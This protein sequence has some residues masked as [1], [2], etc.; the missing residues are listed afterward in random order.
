[1][2]SFIGTLNVF[3]ATAIDPA[4]GSVAVDGQILR[5]G[6][7][8]DAKPGEALGLS[9]RPEA[10]PLGE[11]PNALEGRV[12]NI[13]L[14]GSIVRLVVSPE[15]ILFSRPESAPEHLS[16]IEEE[17]IAGSVTKL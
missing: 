3:P 15:A 9:I 13:K 2:A 14:L 11:G 4:A 7:R 6:K 12:T 1:V 5:T 10:L 17:D 16:E 8:L